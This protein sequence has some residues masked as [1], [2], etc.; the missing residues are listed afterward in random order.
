MVRRQRTFP[1]LDVRISGGNP[2]FRS[3]YTKNDH[4]LDDGRKSHEEWIARRYRKLELSEFLTLVPS[5]EPEIVPDE[6]EEAQIRRDWE[7]GPVLSAIRRKTTRNGLCQHLQLLWRLVPRFMNCLPTDIISLKHDLVYAGSEAM[8]PVPGTTRLQ[9]NI[10]WDI[11]FSKAMQHA[12]FCPNWEASPTTMVIA[13][14]YLICCKTDDR[15]SWR[16]TI[17]N[18]TTDRFLT[19]F[20]AAVSNNDKGSSIRFI[21]QSVKRNPEFKGTEMNQWSD[22]FR[23]VEEKFF[24]KKA[25]RPPAEESRAFQPYKVTAADLRDL[26]DLAGS[27][28]GRTWIRPKTRTHLLTRS[29]RTHDPPMGSTAFRDSLEP[30]GL[31]QLRQ[32][33]RAEKEG[34]VNLNQP[35]PEGTP[36]R[37]PRATE[38]QTLSDVSE[39]EDL[40]EEEES[41]TEG[42]LRKQTPN[43]YDV[44]DSDQDAS[45]AESEANDVSQH[46]TPTV[47]T[48]GRARGI[49]G[50]VGSTERGPGHTREEVSDSEEVSDLEDESTDEVDVEG[51]A[52][53][54]PAGRPCVQLT[55]SATVEH[56]ATADADD[57]SSEGWGGFSDCGSDS[58]DDDNPPP[59]TRQ[60]L[61]I[62]IRAAP[63]PAIP[64]SRERPESPE[65]PR[66]PTGPSP[67]QDCTTP[68]Q[69]LAP[70]DAP[71]PCFAESDSELDEESLAELL[72]AIGP[73]CRAKA[74][75]DE[76]TGPG[77]SANVD[78]EDSSGTK[79]NGQTGAEA[80][81]YGAERQETG[82]RQSQGATTAS[83]LDGNSSTIYAPNQTDDFEIAG[84]A[85]ISD[86]QWAEIAERAD[87]I[88]TS[89]PLR[90]SLD[91]ILAD[92]PP[93]STIVD[94]EPTLPP[95]RPDTPTSG[96]AT[97]PT[98]HEE[99]EPTLPELFPASEE[100][101]LPPRRRPVKTGATP[102][103]FLRKGKRR[104]VPGSEDMHSKRRRYRDIN[105]R[106]REGKLA[107]RGM[108]D[109]DRRRCT[110]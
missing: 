1:P 72:Q 36:E 56:G 19:L 97:L 86:S 50:P 106:I 41:S 104:Q 69:A 74:R 81:T 39:E 24:V 77:D 6:G 15:R 92:I 31:D 75:K 28:Y 2:N 110:Q 34:R 71:A 73:A 100:V 43:V 13:L 48:R 53:F 64:E 45:D 85:V 83:E 59:A 105:D 108:S 107:F 49:D 27:A 87:R 70:H 10:L 55:G 103:Q 47:R 14:K 101:T 91:E 4:F 89:T 65:R 9:P 21:R 25:T 80:S 32:F 58:D 5:T 98:R 3:D 35:T 22:F 40:S 17:E 33:V 51:S 90:Q 20:L 79:G 82:V 78:R 8:L 38:E 93:A 52:R 102:P 23:L 96:E 95:I 30:A 57:E 46:E 16:S 7:S 11:P 66:T 61:V 99:D 63:Q 68:T 26:Y 54:G 37:S 88:A 29:R 84:D 94:D 12:I 42:G 109:E 67:S 60:Q 18:P 76:A 62:E 44:P